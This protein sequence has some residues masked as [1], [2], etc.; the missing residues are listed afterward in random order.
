V[1]LSTLSQALYVRLRRSVLL[2]VMPSG[3]YVV[4]TL[5][6]VVVASLCGD[7]GS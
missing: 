3:F 7:F 1:I 5:L 4:M 2:V 6:C